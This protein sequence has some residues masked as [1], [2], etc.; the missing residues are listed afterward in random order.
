MK[1][2]NI[3]LLGFAQQPLPGN[4]LH[5]AQLGRLIVQKGWTLVTGVPGVPGVRPHALGRGDRRGGPWRFRMSSLRAWFQGE[6]FN[7]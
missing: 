4:Q 6:A 5:A 1:A 2:L 3:A 7:S